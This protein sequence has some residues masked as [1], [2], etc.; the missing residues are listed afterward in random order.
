MDIF[1]KP[2]DFAAFLKLL[3]EARRRFP[4]V[5]ILA[6]CLMNNHWHLVLWPTRGGDLSRF[7]GWL[8]STHVRRWRA[9]RESVG[10]GHLYQGRF[11]SFIVQRD[12][13]LLTLLRYVEANPLRAAIVRRAE[14]WLWSSFGTG[15]GADGV[16]VQLHPW[17]IERPRNWS[18]IVNAQ[19]DDVV[20][21]GIR[22]SIT[23]S[24]PFGDEKWT[25]RIANRFGLE[26]TLR[27]PWRPHGSNR[28]SNMRATSAR[29]R[30]RIDPSTKR[31]Q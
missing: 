20:L 17:P 29:R 21:K 27:N 14:D 8:C 9:H 6:Y 11:K 13:H 4:G 30:A 3:E 24:R 25:Q 28:S 12:E 18:A 31:A 22:T 5:R 2:A 23:R 1:T 7:I 26:S 10:Q 19:L 15:V 16:R